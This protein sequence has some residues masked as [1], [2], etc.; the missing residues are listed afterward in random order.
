MRA[1]IFWWTHGESNPG[2]LHAME[3]CYRYTMGPRRPDLASGLLFPKTAP[4]FLGTLNFLKPLYFTQN[5]R[6]LQ[7][8]WQFL[9]PAP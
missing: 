9:L 5:G 2:L 7:W 4:C 1:E 3:P 6:I 8:L